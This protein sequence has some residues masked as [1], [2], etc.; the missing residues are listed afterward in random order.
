MF[1]QTPF[2]YESL[3]HYGAYDFS[4]KPSEPVISPKRHGVKVGQREKLSDIDITEIRNYYGCE[5]GKIKLFLEFYHSLVF[6]F[7]P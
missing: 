1:Q 6:V 4:Y 2:D 5:K 3:M 7:I